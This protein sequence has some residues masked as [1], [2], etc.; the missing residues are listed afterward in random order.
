MEPFISLKPSQKASR[1]KIH[2]L[3]FASHNTES[4][5][6][7]GSQTGKDPGQSV[8]QPDGASLTK[9]CECSE[10]IV[11]GAFGS[12]QLAALNPPPGITQAINKTLGTKGGHGDQAENAESGRRNRACTQLHGHSPLAGRAHQGHFLSDSTNRD[13]WQHSFQWETCHQGNSL[14]RVTYI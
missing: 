1:L 8:K 10:I 12:Y 13:P 14:P 6:Y 11:G 9:Q 2:Q 5:F 7:L 4:Q 3:S